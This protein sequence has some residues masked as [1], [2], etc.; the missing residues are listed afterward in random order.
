[1]ALFKFKKTSFGYGK[2]IVLI[3]GN[4]LTGNAAIV[5]PIHLTN[6]SKDEKSG[7][8]EFILQ[9]IGNHMQKLSQKNCCCKIKSIHI[10]LKE[11]TL[12]KNIGLHDLEEKHALYLAL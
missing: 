2:H 10:L 9:M 6:Y 8:Q 1:M 12:V 11:I 4:A 3:Q 7:M 5:I